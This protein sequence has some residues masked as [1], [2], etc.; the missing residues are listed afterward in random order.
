MVNLINDFASSIDYEKN[1]AIEDLISDLKI[2]C[3]KNPELNKII[4]NY[5]GK[6]HSNK[7]D[8]A[9]FANILNHSNFNE[10]PQRAYFQS[11]ASNKNNFNEIKMKNIEIN[12]LEFDRNHYTNKNSI[13]SENTDSYSEEKLEKNKDSRKTEEIMSTLELQAQNVKIL[14][15][16]SIFVIKYNKCVNKN[17]CKIYF[18][19]GF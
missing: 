8:H 14:Y 6:M 11:I 15:K 3:N 10:S 4:E 19:L 16:T 17:Y 1:K 7:F 2:Y 18:Y 9:N 12:N 13:I 5:E